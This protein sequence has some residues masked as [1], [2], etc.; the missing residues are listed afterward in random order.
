MAQR[1][2]YSRFSQLADAS[3]VLLLVPSMDAR[4]EEACTSLLT[5]PDPGESN[6]L[7]VTFG[8]SPDDRIEIWRRH[9]GDELPAKAAIVSVGE[10]NR[11]AVAARTGAER[12]EDRVALEFVSDPGDLTGLG[13]RITERLGEWDGDGNRNV[14]C[15]HSLTALLQYAD[16]ERSYRFLH[17]LTGHFESSD[18]LAHYHMDPG[19]HDEQTIN[20]MKTLMDAVIEVDDEDWSVSTR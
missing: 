3:N 9:V 6:V 16:L 17:V 18:T 1:G 12:F 10:G 7:N 4:N 5:V 14:A 11:S 20:T 13:M 8:G 19:A 15:F 2:L